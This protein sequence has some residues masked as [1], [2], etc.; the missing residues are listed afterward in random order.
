MDMKGWKWEVIVGRRRAGEW[1]LGGSG[2][3]FQE[4]WGMWVKAEALQT[5]WQWSWVIGGAGDRRPTH[6]AQWSGVLESGLPPHWV[7]L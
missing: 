1:M 6:P 3:A 7:L 4:Q 5:C 2:Q